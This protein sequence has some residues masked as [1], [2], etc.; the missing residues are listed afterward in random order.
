LSVLRS[1]AYETGSD[2]YRRERTAA[3]RAM[4]RVE[5]YLEMFRKLRRS[6]EW[7]GVR[8]E[9]SDACHRVLTTRKCNRD[10]ERVRALCAAGVLSHATCPYIMRK[11]LR[12]P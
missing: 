8:V 5:A 9:V 4:N 1:H 7:I 11:H 3:N 6:D 12:A 10:A 2:P